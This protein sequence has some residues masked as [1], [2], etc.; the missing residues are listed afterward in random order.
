MNRQRWMISTPGQLVSTMKAVIWSLLRPRT[1]LGGVFAMTTMTPARVP[2]VHHILQPFKVNE[3]S[4][5]GSACVSMRAGSDPDSR[6]GQRKG[7]DFPL[8]ESRQV[9]LALL[10]GPEEQQRL[11][12]PDRLMSTQERG[13]I[14]AP[15]SQQH[16]RAAVSRLR[17]T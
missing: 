5:F 16:R 8:G 10:F 13:H 15:T 14:T 2:F 9:F 11:R 1:T 12:N 4:P 7:R 6:L 17:E 3:R